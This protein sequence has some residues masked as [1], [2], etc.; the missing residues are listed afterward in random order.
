M[1][2]VLTLLFLVFAS[3][4]GVRTFDCENG[5][6]GLDM[7]V[8]FMSPYAETTTNWLDIFCDT[9]ESL[10]SI[11]KCGRSPAAHVE[12]CLM[13]AGG[14]GGAARIYVSQEEDTALSVCH[15]LGHARPVV[16]NTESGCPT[17]TADCGWD[18]ELEDSCMEAVIQSR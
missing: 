14:P 11:T 10:S 2:K 5:V 3:S 16:W 17:H 8:E 13:W 7:A 1:N 12:A 18:F 6:D 9:E 4:C 15:E